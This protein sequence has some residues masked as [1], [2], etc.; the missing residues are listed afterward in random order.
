MR[1]LSHQGLVS[2][3]DVNCHPRALAQILNE[4][5]VLQD[6]SFAKRALSFIKEPDK[7]VSMRKVLDD[8]VGLFQVRV[9]PTFDDGIL[10]HTTPLAELHDNHRLGCC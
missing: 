5:K 3:P 6:K 4:I 9:T 8:A 2:C 10:I 7:I 1:F